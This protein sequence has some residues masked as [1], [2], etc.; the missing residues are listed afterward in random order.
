[1]GKFQLKPLAVLSGL[2]MVTTMTA[3]VSTAYAADTN[4]AAESLKVAQSGLP[5]KDAPFDQTVAY[6]L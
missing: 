5:A 3:G 4:N 1:M 2:A 6:L